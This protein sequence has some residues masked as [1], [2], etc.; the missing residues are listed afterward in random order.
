MEAPKESEDSGKS[1]S[2]RFRTVADAARRLLRVLGALVRSVDFAVAAAVLVWLATTIKFLEDFPRWIAIATAAAAIGAGIAHRAK[3]QRGVIGV[4]ACG[5]AIVGV[6]S[7]LVD[8]G[9]ADTSVGQNSAPLISVV[10]GL[11]ASL[12]VK[13]QSYGKT[14]KSVVPADGNDNLLFRLRIENPTAVPSRPVVMRVL[15]PLNTESPRSVEICFSRSEIGQCEAG[16]EIKVVAQSNGLDMFHADSPQLGY[17]SPAATRLIGLGGQ[18]IHAAGGNY[19]GWDYMVP[20]ISAH[21]TILVTFEASYWTPEDSSQLSGGSVMQ[22]ENLTEN[23][24]KYET[25]VAAQPG[26]VL[27][28]YG[29]L[30]NTGFRSTSVFAR[31]RIRSHDKGAFAW[32]EL[33]ARE[34]FAGERE[35]GHG[36][37][38]ASTNRPIGLSV[39]PGSTELR[40]ADTA[41]SNETREPLADGVTK[42]GLELGGIGGFKPRDPCH[43]SEWIRYLFFKLKV[44]EAS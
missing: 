30:N 29:T 4:T 7:Y 6:V 38:N 37:V 44:D 36:V 32:V 33:F 15:S 10:A 35:L 23:S 17:P 20:A 14:W 21:Q 42:G 12:E 2:Q 31:V 8:Q 41:C 16:P 1:R 34:S 11:R 9:G 5:V 40:A 3:F 13:N 28:A 25:V 19:E 22:F 39:V 18:E 24:S 43:G 26:D 27:Q